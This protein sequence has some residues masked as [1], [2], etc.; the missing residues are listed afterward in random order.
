MSRNRLHPVPHTAVTLSD[1]FWAPRL[2]VNREVTLPIEYQQ[3]KQTG[4][5]DAWKLDWTP[6]QGEPPHIFWDSDVAKWIEAA[7]YSLASHPD[8]ALRQRVETVIADIALAQQPDGYLNIHFTVVAPEK[9]WTNLR[10]CHELYCAGHLMEAAVAWTEAL[11]DQALLRVMCRY[12]DCIAATFGRGR[13]QRRGYPGHEEIEL[14][15]MR[16]HRATGETRYRDLATYFV[17]E[18]G[19]QPHYFAREA[20]ARGKLPATG[21]H[22]TFEYNQSHVPVREQ[23]TAVGHAVRACYLYAGMADVAAAT[24]DRALLKACRAIWQSLT[25]RRMHL[26]GGIGPT[27]RNEGFT[28]DYDLPTESAYLET[29]AAI[30][31]C[32]FAERMLN[33]TR[34]GQFAD[35]LERALFNGVASGVSLDGERFFYGNPLAAQPGFDGNGVWQGAGYHYRRSPWFGCACCPPN[36]ARLFASLPQYMASVGRRSL[37]LHLYAEGV[38]E[39]EVAGTGVTIRQQTGYPWRESVRLRVDVA[40]PVRFT[41]ALR[42]PGW[43]RQPRLTLAGQRLPLGAT[44]RTGY[45]RVE[46][47]WQGGETL[48]LVLPMPVERIQAHPA[49]RQTAGCIALQR[50]PVVYCLE[51][52]DNGPRLDTLR[53][54]D[55]AVL[56]PRWEPDLLGGVMTLRAKARREVVS[57]WQGHLYRPQARAR[58]EPAQLTA[59]PYATWA[60]R[61]PGEMRVW[62]RPGG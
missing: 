48:E 25:A 10:D 46:R 50:G 17:D 27:C 60:N 33:L 55:R 35:V 41:L 51:E 1:P 57:D 36:I 4:R 53:L 13:G 34:E 49:A 7:A 45:A 20:R 61:E 6:A 47:T 52:A 40:R 2:R 54:P 14:A 43:C 16:L 15:L 31:L 38:T 30:A 26:T 56:R 3:C 59:V 58:T 18:R 28:A 22:G 8:A 24:G 5:I 11:G 9:R 29:C 21:G 32:F 12:A 37:Y 23:R 62:L 39:V 42:L 44:V 19:R